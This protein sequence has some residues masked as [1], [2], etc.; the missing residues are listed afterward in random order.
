MFL[1]SRKRTSIT[2]FFQCWMFTGYTSG[3]RV[4]HDNLP[5]CLLCVTDGSSRPAPLLPIINRQQESGGINQPLVALQHTSPI[6]K[7]LHILNRIR[8]I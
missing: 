3:N 6:I 7:P 2:A 5:T 8:F 4:N 1:G